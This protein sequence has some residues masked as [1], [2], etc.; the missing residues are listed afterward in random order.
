M[1][2]LLRAQPFI[3]PDRDHILPAVECDNGMPIGLLPSPATHGN[4][5]NSL[6]LA[7]VSIG[8]RPGLA[9]SLTPHSEK[10]TVVNW[11]IHAGASTRSLL[12]QGGWRA[13]DENMPL[14]YGRR[15]GA[16]SLNLPRSCCAAS[17]TAGRPPRTSPSRTSS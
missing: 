10:A 2:A 3:D 16:I 14:K 6:R 9:L 1:L 12:V 17:A 7:L 4:Y 15:L 5:A 11:G 13:R 8:V